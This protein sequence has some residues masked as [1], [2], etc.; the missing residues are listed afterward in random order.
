[1]RRWRKACV[2]ILLLLACAMLFPVGFVYWQRR[3]A[4]DELQAVLAETD[5]TDPGWRLED[6]EAARRVVPDERNGA[7]VVLAAHHKLPAD[8]SSDVA[9]ELHNAPPPLKLAD[10]VAKQVRSEHQVVRETVNVAR[11]LIDH[12][13]GRFAITYAGDGMT[14]NIEHVQITRTIMTVLTLDVLASLEVGQVETAF[15]SARA[16]LNAG[17][18]LGDE[19]TAITPLVRMAIQK[20]AV[21]CL[22]RVLAH[23]E[24]NDTEL[25]SAQEAVRAEAGERL[26]VVGMRGDRAARHRCFCWLAEEAPSIS[27]AVA[28][29]GL[30]QP[31]RDPTWRDRLDDIFLLKGIY[32]SHAWALK[33]DN[34]VVAATLHSE[35]AL[36]ARAEE[37][38]DNRSHEL[39]VAAVKDRDMRFAHV[40]GTAVTKYVEAEQRADTLLDCAQVAI[41]AERFR[42]KHRRWPT[43]LRELTAEKWLPAVPSDRFNGRPLSMRRATNGLVIFSTGKDNQYAGDALDRFEEFDPMRQ[44]IEFRL[45]DPLDRQR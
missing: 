6:L 4:F 14:T 30:R 34:D 41:A 13:D 36:L 35:T 24:L 25:K 11:R 15:H 33:F 31:E 32:R 19:P 23:G 22:E 5:R 26:L 1:M 29:L 43:S 44:R 28:A 42:L 45:W 10:A 40:F 39:A 37:L 12:P 20:Q 38:L 21:A 27:T 8:W 3:Q 17:R 7:L 16:I 18:A 9:D 2:Y